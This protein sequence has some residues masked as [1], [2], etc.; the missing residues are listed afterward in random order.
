VVAVSFYFLLASRE[1]E[2]IRLVNGALP[3]EEVHREV[4]GIV[5]NLLRSRDA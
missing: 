5:D 3:P 4:R 1:P 2:R